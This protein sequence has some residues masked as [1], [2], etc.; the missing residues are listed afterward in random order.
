[1]TARVFSLC[2]PNATMRMDS[3]LRL[4][5]PKARLAAG[6]RC[7]GPRGPDSNRH[8]PNGQF[9]ALPVEL[10]RDRARGL[11]MPWSVRKMAETGVHV[12]DIYAPGVSK[13][14][15]ASALSS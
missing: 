7:P 3:S 10:P 14:T 12:V 6:L 13:T 9:V 2:T 11:A 15:C 8:P 4:S 1:S 5:Y